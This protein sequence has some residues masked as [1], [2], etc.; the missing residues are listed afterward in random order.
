VPLAAGFLT[1]PQSSCV[2]AALLADKLLELLVWSAEL[3]D[4]PVVDGLRRERD[5]VGPVVRPGQEV[6]AADRGLAAG[7][8]DVVAAFHSQQRGNEDPS[9]GVR[10]CADF[11]AAQVQPRLVTGQSAPC[12]VKV[13]VV[14]HQDGDVAAPLR[15]GV[16][17]CP[18]SFRLRVTADQQ[19]NPAPVRVFDVVEFLLEQRL[20]AHEAAVRNR[21]RV[22]HLF[23]L[24]RPVLGVDAGEP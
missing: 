14:G 24:P 19:E 7:Y 20:R 15:L 5:V 13:R 10:E 3:P 16:E 21:Q 1:K 9:S 18:G 11:A 2:R 23:Q 4:R 6:H 22:Q 8:D 17:V 12:V